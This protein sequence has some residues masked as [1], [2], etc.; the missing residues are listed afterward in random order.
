LFQ[1]RRPQSW[2]FPTRDRSP[3]YYKSLQSLGLEVMRDL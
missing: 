3:D 1:G 2:S